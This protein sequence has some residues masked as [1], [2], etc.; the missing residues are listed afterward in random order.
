MERRSIAELIS[1][2]EGLLNDS[3]SRIDEERK[4]IA[5]RKAIGADLAESEQL[6]ANFEMRHLARVSVALPS[7]ACRQIRLKRVGKHP[8][9]TTRFV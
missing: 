5:H 6:L 8:A 4:V 3:R 2:A 9:L 7:A 1:E